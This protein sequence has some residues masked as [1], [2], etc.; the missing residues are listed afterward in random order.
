LGCCDATIEGF[1]GQSEFE[2]LTLCP[3]PPLDTVSG[4]WRHSEIH[5]HDFDDVR[6]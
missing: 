1:G 6:Q 3:P 4:S 2:A 5:I